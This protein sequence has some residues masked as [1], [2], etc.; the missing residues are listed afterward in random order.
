MASSTYVYPARPVAALIVPVS[1]S[2]SGMALRSNTHGP[3]ASV[4]PLMY[5]VGFVKP[6][7]SAACSSTIRSPK[8]IGTHC[9]ARSLFCRRCRQ[10]SGP[11]PAGS[12][13]V[14]AIFGRL[15]YGFYFP[16]YSGMVF[17]SRSHSFLIFPKVSASF[18]DR[19]FSSER[20]WAKLYSCHFPWALSSFQSPCLSAA[21]FR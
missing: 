6:H 9:L 4:K 13:M 19:S 10:I 11:M 18:F 14:T 1:K 20:S 21:L 5:V 8:M 17:R 16:L 15:I 3:S 2:L 7:C 12:P